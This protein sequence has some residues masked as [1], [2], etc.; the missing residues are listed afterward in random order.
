[1]W[2]TVYGRRSLISKV[3]YL[4]NK[5]PRRGHQYG[6]A[7]DSQ[8]D[9]ESLNSCHLL[10]M[11]VK[12]SE[13]FGPGRMKTRYAAGS[14]K[15][16]NINILTWGLMVS[17]RMN[18]KQSILDMFRVDRVTTK[19]QLSKGCQHWQISH[20]N[21]T[22]LR[23]KRDAPFQINNFELKST[24]PKTDRPSPTCDVPLILQH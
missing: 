11:K 7:V 12:L 10:Y 21:K 5:Y 17:R 23:A 8:R 15:S 3:A 9:I 19:S 4:Q 2:A 1:M 22:G 18:P 13:G 16:L 24:L 14:S 6:I 20:S